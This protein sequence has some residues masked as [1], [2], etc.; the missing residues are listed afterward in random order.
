MS[1]ILN[2]KLGVLFNQQQRSLLKLQ[3]GMTPPS[4]VLG[5]FYL[6]DTL[7]WCDRDSRGDALCLPAVL[8]V[9]T[10]ARQISDSELLYSP[11]T[12]SS[13]QSTFAARDKSL[14]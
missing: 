10:P 6:L 7:R 12:L 4:G 11:C 8:E 14:G 13:S 2:M 1:R 9:R 5:V 3:A